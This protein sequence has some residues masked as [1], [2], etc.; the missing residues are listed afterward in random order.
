MTLINISALGVTLGDPLFSDL[1][2]TISKADRI[3]LVAA[4]GRG[5]STL[6][7]CL[8]GL[9][10]QTTGEITRARGLRVGYVQLPA[11]DGGADSLR[12][13]GLRVGYVQQDVPDDALALTL[14]DWVL[15]ALPP[16]QAEYESWRVDVVLDDLKVPTELHHLQLGT[17][18]GGWQR[19]AM[20]AAV[21]ITE[22]DVLLLDEPT[23][24]L[25]LRRI[26]LLQDWL[27][28]LPRDVPVVMTF[29]LPTSCSAFDFPMRNPSSR[30]DKRENPRHMTVVPGGGSLF[31]S[32][33]PPSRAMMIK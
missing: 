17:L 26:G 18:S 13:R 19:T 32:K 23:N 1:N 7:A 9:S 21:W 11:C 27:A 30:S 2:L 29:Q 25:D 6:L 28:A 14:Y 31:R 33:Y 20:L 3:G 15:A 22:P 12:A 8:A 4:N 24:H 5:K 16:E 10:D